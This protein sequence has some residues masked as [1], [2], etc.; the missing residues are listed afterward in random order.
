MDSK[1]T[2]WLALCTNMSCLVYRAKRKGM[3]TD[4]MASMSASSSAAQRA[5]VALTPAYI[6]SFMPALRDEEDELYKKHRKQC[7]EHMRSQARALKWETTYSIPDVD[8][9]DVHVLDAVYARIVQWLRSEHFVV[10]TD[11]SNLRS[12][13]VSWDPAANPENIS[14]EERADPNSNAMKRLRA[15]Q[16]RM[17]TA[18]VDLPVSYAPY[19]PYRAP[20]SNQTTSTAPVS[21]FVARPTPPLVPFVNPFDRFR[22]E[23]IAERAASVAGCAPT[24]EPGNTNDKHTQPPPPPPLRPITPAVS[25]PPAIRSVTSSPPPPPSVTPVPATASARSSKPSSPFVEHSDGDEITVRISQRSPVPSV[26]SAR[27]DDNDDNDTQSETTL[28][29]TQSNRSSRGGRF[30]ADSDSASETE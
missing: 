27:D 5:H 29:T 1:A 25:P 10:E 14:A 18:A 20:P 9:T 15:V 16:R 8:D 26:H 7:Y 2:R 22:S 30:D 19:A 21:H 4:A 17:R 6:R 23:Q 11:S 13:I 3:A 28:S 12:I 24:P